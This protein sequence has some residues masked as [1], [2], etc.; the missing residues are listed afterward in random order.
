GRA[1]P[2]QPREPGPALS[3]RRTRRD[4]HR[5][6]GPTGEASPVRQGVLGPR[7]PGHRVGVR[8]DHP[9][10]ARRVQSARAG[11]HV[12]YG[13]GGLP[14][15]QVPTGRRPGRSDRPPRTGLKDEGEPT[16]AAV[17]IIVTTFNIEDYIDQCLSS[18]AAQTL[19]DIEVI[20]VDDGSSDTTP[21][22]ITQF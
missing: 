5:A 9:G 8:S 2:D 14:P 19:T 12:A 18:V 22:R 10:R 15:D 16:V 4:L 11:A 17:S 6:R 13:P 21:E 3:G 20:V 1:Q 7:H